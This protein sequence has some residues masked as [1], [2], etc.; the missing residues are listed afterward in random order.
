MGNLSGIH[1]HVYCGKCVRCKAWD[2]VHAEY[3]RQSNTEACLKCFG[4]GQ[5]PVRHDPWIKLDS[6]R[7]ATHYW[8]PCDCSIDISAV[9]PRPAPSVGKDEYLWHNSDP[10]AGRCLM[11]GE[12]VGG[13]MV[14]WR[15]EGKWT[16]RAT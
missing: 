7:F 14:D 6:G 11:P 3:C 16:M 15:E 8:V 13:G 10:L 5:V 1:A 4:S 9:A 12:K 2:T